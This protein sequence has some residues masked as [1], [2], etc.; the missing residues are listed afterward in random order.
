MPDEG[1]RRCPY[2][3]EEIRREAVKCRYCGSYVEGHALKRAWYRVRRGKR[4]AGVCAGLAREFD[5]S[6]TLVRLA[7]V[8][9]TLIGGPGI[10][11]Y[12]ALWIIM[13]YDPAEELPPTDSG[14][15]RPAAA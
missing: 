3:A 12:L 8:L 9:A 2:C 11:I 15:G 4:I 1:M 10:I 6:V 13:P 7:F 14:R 5:V